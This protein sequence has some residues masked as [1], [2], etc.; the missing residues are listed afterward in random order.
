MLHLSI[1]LLRDVVDS[2][3]SS[4]L[5]SLAT[6]TYDDAG[7]QFYTPPPPGPLF[8]CLAGLTGFFKGTLTATVYK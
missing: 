6:V 7:V 8:W 4:F 1:C 5:S 3:N 2:D